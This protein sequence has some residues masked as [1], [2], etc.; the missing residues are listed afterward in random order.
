VRRSGVVL[1]LLL[2]GC[3]SKPADVTPITNEGESL[4]KD[5]T[6]LLTARGALQRER[7]KI[8]DARAEIVERRKQLGHDS[9]GQAALDEEDKK[10]IERE[11][12]LHSKES[13]L[14]DKLQS[15]LK[16]Q[17][18]LLQKATSAV[19]SSPG[20]DPL[21][22]A[23]RREQTVAQREKELAQRE[24]DVAQRE[25]ELADREARQA[26]REKEMCGGTS[27]PV[28]IELP[29]GLKYSSRDVEPIYKKALRIMQ[30][31]G[32][33]AADLPPG[34][35][36]LVD[37]VRE[38]MKKADY[39]RAKY[40]ADAL[41]AAV[42]DM[43]IDR[44]FI[45][46]KMARLNAAIKGRKFDGEKRKDVESLFRDATVDYGDGKFPSANTKINKLFA[47]MK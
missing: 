20:A 37:E 34:Q 36:K 21:E 15:L 27:A 19:A 5:E 18:A 2:T 22:R 31:K 12:D 39:V 24:K 33:L 26:R 47:L 10:L 42:E 44:A 30:D 23:A 29:K 46:A 14:D 3:P 35:A 13:D 16:Q 17:S 11:N 4:K 6:D 43:K 41:L 25:K 9:V 28:A 7:K 1:L 32:V 8:S 40:D 45:F 38:L